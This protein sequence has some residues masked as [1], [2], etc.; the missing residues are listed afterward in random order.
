MTKDG[1][2]DGVSILLF[3]LAGV[4]LP[5]RGRG[6]AGG[7]GVK[8]LLRGVR[9]GVWLDWLDGVTFGGGRRLDGSGITGSL[10][11]ELGVSELGTTLIG[12]LGRGVGVR[13][14]GWGCAEVE[15]WEGT[16]DV[17]GREE[18]NWGRESF[19]L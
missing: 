14:P 8:V 13:V 15:G 6:P 2:G 12:S 17:F 7:D 9:S 5:E 18:G 4:E 10:R 3:R 1:I 16:L 11:I 19:G